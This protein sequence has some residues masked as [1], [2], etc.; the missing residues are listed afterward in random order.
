MAVIVIDRLGRERLRLVVAEAHHVI[1]GDFGQLR[2]RLDR[3]SVV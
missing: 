3:K 2:V 1:G